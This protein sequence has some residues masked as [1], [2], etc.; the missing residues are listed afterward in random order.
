[1]LQRAKFA[2]SFADQETLGISMYEAACA[3]A[4]PIVPNRLSYNEMYSP[5]F[6]R[7]D[8]VDDAVCAILEY[9]NNDI[10]TDIAQLVTILHENFFS[11]TNL[12][13][14]IKEYNERS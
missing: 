12:I 8:S 6:K 7:A 1:L 4:C 3:G 9:E 11:A 10:T 2:V 13:N 5:M 14:K